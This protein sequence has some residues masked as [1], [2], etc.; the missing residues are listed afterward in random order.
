MRIFPQ[1]NLGSAHF[2][3]FIFTNQ[4]NEQVTCFFSYKWLCVCNH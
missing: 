1:E 4:N 3:D 2:E